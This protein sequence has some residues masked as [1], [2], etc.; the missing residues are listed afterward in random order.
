MK[1]FKKL[2]S[3]GLVLGLILLL[4]GCSGGGEKIK[5]E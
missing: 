3:L 2:L 1:V 5:L 4:V